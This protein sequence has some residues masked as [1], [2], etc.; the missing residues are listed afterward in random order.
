M[1]NLL[2]F[3]SLALSCAASGQAPAEINYQGIA[4]N[5]VGNVL[6][7]KNITIRLSVH[8]ANGTGPVV[9]QEVRKITTSN[10][11]M[12]NIAIG[13]AGAASVQGTLGAV[14]WGAGLKFLQVELDATGGNNFIDLGTGQLL[15]VPYAMYAE[16]SKP[17][18]PAS[19]DLEGNY[20]NPDLG[21]GK[22]TTLKLADGSVA[23][24]KIKDSA[25]TLEKIA[26][27][28]IPVTLPPSGVAAGD[29]VGT[30]P[31]PQVGAGVITT[32]KLADNAVSS[33]K[34]S[35]NSIT[36]AKISDGVITAAKLAPGVIPTSL[37]ASG[38]A[39]GDLSGTFPN[40]QVA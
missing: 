12:F 17:T 8:D 40:P 25:I 3:I 9:Y 31:N 6:A 34:L 35:D 2:L 30:Y 36:T 33:T 27:G 38:A 10:L 1:R 29:L 18:G 14:N 23:T 26:T 7:Q 20:P 13:S 32:N 21:N 4:R 16:K 28:V 39:G 15:S 22:V 19:G 11:G 37:P 5:A 24:V